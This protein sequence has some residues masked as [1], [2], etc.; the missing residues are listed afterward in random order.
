MWQ[1]SPHPVPCRI[2]NAPKYTLSHK[3]FAI[4]RTLNS[5]LPHDTLWH[6]FLITCNTL[7]HNL[8]QKRTPCRIIFTVKGHPVERHIPSSQ[9]WEYP[10]PLAPENLV[11]PFLRILCPCLRGF[12]VFAKFC[13]LKFILL[14][15]PFF[16]SFY[17][18]I[19]SSY[20]FWN[21]L[22][23]SEISFPSICWNLTQ[24]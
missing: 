1:I 9:V 11:S 2:K 24:R 12:T 21:T 10:P 7:S 19:R 6:N 22:S 17:L 18:N 8:Y 13:H 4:K 20:T 23:C 3:N 15:S 16:S 14:C 5:V